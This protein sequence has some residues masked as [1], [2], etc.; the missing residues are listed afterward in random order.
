MV[1]NL[2][3]KYYCRES[4][5]HSVYHSANAFTCL[6]HIRSLY[7]KKK[8]R[9][10]EKFSLSPSFYADCEHCDCS[11]QNVSPPYLDLTI[12]QH[13]TF[14]FCIRTCHLVCP[15]VT[16]TS[17]TDMSTVATLII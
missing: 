3:K 17:C 2:L 5:E 14:F 13:K 10:L 11:G 4:L 12:C 1:N 6:S 7:K 8:K 9:V 15:G 16:D